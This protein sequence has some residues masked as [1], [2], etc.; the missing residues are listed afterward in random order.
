MD[1]TQDDFEQHSAKVIDWLA[2]IARERPIEDIGVAKEIISLLIRL[3][4]NTQNLDIIKEIA[5]D[6]HALQGEVDVNE[7]S[8]VEPVIEYQMIN[9]R[10]HSAITTQVLTFT[11]QETDVLTWS[12]GRLKISGKRLLPRG[13][14]IWFSRFSHSASLSCPIAVSDDWDQHCCFE[15]VICDRLIPYV[16]IVSELLKSAM[17]GVHAEHLVKVLTKTYRMFT[18]LVK[19]VRPKHC[20]RGYLLTCSFVLENDHT[21]N[22]SAA[23]IHQRG[24]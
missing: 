21:Q 14:K 2:Q 24:S 6:V 15:Q 23:R 12:I 13:G 16:A 7:D 19:Y 17:V 3:C 8:Q 22:W 9:A 20:R 5:Q 18:V 4:A 1:H 11:E 10:T